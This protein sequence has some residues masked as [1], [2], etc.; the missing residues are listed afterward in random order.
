VKPPEVF[1]ASVI[2]SDIALAKAANGRKPTKTIESR[3]SLARNTLSEK[4][5]VS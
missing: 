1:A 5:R 2:L 4:A 3:K